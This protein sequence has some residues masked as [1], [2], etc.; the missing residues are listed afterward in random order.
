MRDEK[1]RET[2]RR[3]PSGRTRFRRVKEAC[4]KIKEC[5]VDKHT[6]IGCGHH[7]P[8][9]RKIG[10]SIIREYQGNTGPSGPQASMDPKKEM[11]PEECRKILSKISNEDMKL[12]GFDPVHARPEWM[13]IKTLTIGPPPVRPSVQAGDGVRSEDDLTYSYRMIVRTNNELRRYMEGG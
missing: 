9:Y 8:N 1:L 11:K 13:I 7:Q 3:K 6:G 2:I 5:H 10:L 4:M 12:M